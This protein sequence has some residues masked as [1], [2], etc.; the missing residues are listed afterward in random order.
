MC[1][2][3]TTYNKLRV[4]KKGNTQFLYFSYNSFRW[5]LACGTPRKSC[6]VIN[7]MKLNRKENH[8]ARF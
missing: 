6:S 3:H 7:G 5:A 4:T 2:T 8:P 1:H